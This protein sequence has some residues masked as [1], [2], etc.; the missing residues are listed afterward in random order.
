LSANNG[1]L[2]WR[3]EPLPGWHVCEPVFSDG[4]RLFAL[5]RQ[6]GMSGNPAMIIAFGDG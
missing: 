2:V 4:T 3:F 6:F 1:E 5:T